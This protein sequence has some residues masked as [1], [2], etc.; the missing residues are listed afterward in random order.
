MPTSTYAFFVPSAVITFVASLAGLVTAETSGK[1]A[2]QSTADLA[3]RRA[4][5]RPCYQHV[6]YRH[7]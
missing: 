7:D 5:T 1:T 6:R 3:G 2:G 4:A